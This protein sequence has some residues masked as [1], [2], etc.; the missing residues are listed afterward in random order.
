MFIYVKFI[1]NYFTP[2]SWIHSHP[3][4]KANPQLA[5]WTQYCLEQAK[6]Y[7]TF[8]SYRS[9]QNIYLKWCAKNFVKP[10][11]VDPTVIQF[12][13]AQRS[14][15]VAISSIKKDL[16]AIRDLSICYGFPIE[17]KHFTN[18]KLIKHGIKNIFGDKTSDIRAGVTFN[19]LKLFYKHFDMNQ[20]DDLMF[21]TWLVIMVFNMLRPGEG[22]A[23]NK[24]VSPFNSNKASQSAL[25]GRN[26]HL[27]LNENDNSKVKYAIID[28][29]ATKNAKH[30][31]IVET[32]I[33][34][35]IDPLNPLKLL[36]AYLCKRHQLSQFN[37]KLKLTP[38]APLFCW[39]DGSILTVNDSSKIIK[40]LA[41]LCNLKGK[42]TNQ[43][44]RI[45]GATSYAQRNY[46]NIAIQKAGRWRSNAFKS[47]IRFDND[48][49]AKLPL[50]ALLK[51]IIDENTQFGYQS[52]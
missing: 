9:A 42:F 23:E 32:I 7:S 2:Y 40:D 36:L 29:K 34:E 10:L 28:L 39:L 14:T 46:S 3:I 33:G 16:S 19:I 49:F 13:M 8:K 25:W 15:K 4:A 43:S 1:D 11:P 5:K 6:A 24:S 31:Q 18:I 50:A 51:P 37:P 52:Q 30:N 48:Y 38:I 47:Y 41:K 35:G 27:I 20:Y 17:W 26:L 44:L 45:G 12:Y 22:A 21:F